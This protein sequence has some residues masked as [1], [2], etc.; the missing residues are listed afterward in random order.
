MDE[1]NEVFASFKKI[2]KPEVQE[3]FSDEGMKNYIERLKIIDKLKFRFIPDYNDEIC[4][5][6]EAKELLPLMEE[7]VK[8]WVAQGKDFYIGPWSDRELNKKYLRFLNDYYTGA[9][10]ILQPNGD[11]KKFVITEYYS[12]NR[13]LYMKVEYDSVEECFEFAV[14][15]DD[16]HK[17]VWGFQ[18][19]FTVTYGSISKVPSDI[20]NGV[21]LHE[22]GYRWSSRAGVMNS[23]WKKDKI[24]FRTHDLSG[25]VAIPYFI[26]EE[27][28]KIL[29]GCFLVDGDDY[30]ISSNIISPF[31]ECNDERFD[32]GDMGIADFKEK[33]GL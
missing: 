19:N 29:P 11:N 13:Q 21:A 16:S 26:A 23:F 28:V 10:H 7:Y 3:N 33:L 17:L 25:S 1:L 20:R 6:R 22:P 30:E 32:R 31:I 27:I 5:T 14:D 18:D 4:R 2:T 24:P 12:V 8:N 9:L 15:E